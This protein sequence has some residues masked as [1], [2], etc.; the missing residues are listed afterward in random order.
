MNIRV[1]IEPSALV[2]CGV[3]LRIAESDAPHLSLAA[4]LFGI[5]TVQRLA[6]WFGQIVY[7][8]SYGRSFAE[9]PSRY[10]SSRGIYRGRGWPQLTGEWAGPRNNRRPDAPGNYEEYRRYLAR[11]DR[12]EYALVPYAEVVRRP[13]LVEQL[14][15]RAHAAG[16]YWWKENTNR[17]ADAGFSRDHVERIIRNIWRPAA[18]AF[19]TDR[20]WEIAQTAYRVLSNGGVR[21]T[22]CEGASCLRPGLQFIPDMRPRPV[23]TFPMGFY[24]WLP[25]GGMPGLGGQQ[26]DLTAFLAGLTGLFAGGA[27]SADPSAEEPSGSVSSIPVPLLLAAGAA[28]AAGLL[29]LT[30]S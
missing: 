13:E 17:Y 1:D 6:H 11:R 3:P 18:S 26:P 29:Y 21:L 25:G 19:A 15:Y 22:P 10:A 14:P 4:T 16:W 8:S 28:G 23:A 5:N 24:D 2:A 9:G 27:A 12:P 20:R 7:E 30:R